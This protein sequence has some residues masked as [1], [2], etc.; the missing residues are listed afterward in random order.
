MPTKGPR[1]EPNLGGDTNLD[2]RDVHV[3]RLGEYSDALRQLRERGL[4]GIVVR[5]AFDAKTVSTL[6]DRFLKLPP[7]LY[8]NTGVTFGFPKAFG[9]VAFSI[10]AEDEA[11]R[12]D[13]LR[14]YFEESL[15][16]RRESQAL[17][18]V[19]VEGVVM[20]LLA[21]LSGG[22]P[23]RIPAGYDGQG[24]YAGVTTRRYQGDKRPHGEIPI[25]CGNFFQQAFAPFYV[26]LSEMADVRDQL[27]FYVMLDPPTRGGELTL[28]DYPYE[29]GQ[30]LVGFGDN[31]HVKLPNGELADFADPSLTRRVSL[32]LNAGDMI[33]FAGGTVW[34]RVEPISA[35]T[36]RVT[37]GGF[38]GP[39]HDDA[40]IYIWA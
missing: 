3:S 29:H 18:G 24:S 14:R 12:T 8:D 26:H 10:R 2:I 36:T 39:S 19:D 23:V 40:T 30:G 27:S 28:F 22:R 17:L 21:K 11:K 38:I 9:S 15:A 35:E 5:E 37:A 6:L 34:H 7:A 33:V 4:E 31:R 1:P 13:V 25:H 16:M 20:D 32:P